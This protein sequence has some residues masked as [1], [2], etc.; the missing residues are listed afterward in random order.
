MN[1]LYLMLSIYGALA[2]VIGFGL[3]VYLTL[4]KEIAAL[5]SALRA[6]GATVAGTDA[7]GW[8]ERRREILALAKEGIRESAIAAQLRVPVSEVSFA[9]RLSRSHPQG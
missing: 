6:D 2:A 8:A 4:N 7:E 1:E 9:L 5:R 3:W